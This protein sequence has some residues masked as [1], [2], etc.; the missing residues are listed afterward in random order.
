MSKLMTSLTLV[1]ALLL[2]ACSTTSPDVVQRQTRLLE[3]L[4]LPTRLPPEAAAV[5]SADAVLVAMRHDK[6]AV[7][8]RIT[9]ILPTRIG[10]VESVTDAADADVRAALHDSQ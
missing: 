5:C 8:G 9:F 1:G 3:T 7:G 4:R 6:K 2:S 10:Q